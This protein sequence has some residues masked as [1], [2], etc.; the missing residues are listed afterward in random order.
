MRVRRFSRKLAPVMRVFGQLDENGSVPVISAKQLHR[1]RREARIRKRGEPTP[2]DVQR[3]AQ[4]EAKRE[5]RRARNQM[6][7]SPSA[8]ESG[9]VHE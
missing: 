8:T 1:L 4:A 3:F 5:R 2:A 6:D 9:M 7:T